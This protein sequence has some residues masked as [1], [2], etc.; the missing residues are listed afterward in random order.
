MMRSMRK[1][2][3]WRVSAAILLMSLLVRLMPL[4]LYVTPDE[5]IWVERSIRFVDAFLSGDWSRI[6]Q[7]GHPGLTTMVLGGIG[8]SLMRL[9]YPARSA[10]H[11]DWIARIAW[12]APENDEAFRHLAFFLPAGRCLTALTVSLGMVALYLLGR[13]RFG[14]RVARTAAV[15]LAL[16]PFYAGH[17]GL[18]HTDALQ[19]TFITLA[20]VA[21]YPPNCRILPGSQP[22]STSAINRWLRW[23]TVSLMLALAGLTK[24]LG[25]AAAP[26]LALA[27]M[28]WGPGSLWQRIRRVTLLALLTAALVVLLYPPSW[29]DPAAT[30]VSFSDAVFYHEGIGLRD[31]FFAGQMHVDPGP[32]FY[33][34]VLLFRLTPPVMVGMLLYIYRWLR[35][36]E[37]TAPCYFG[38]FALPAC[39]Y[40]VVITVATKKF[41]RYVLMTV[42]LL[43]I[44]AAYSWGRH[45]RAWRLTLLASL[46]LPWVW[47]AVAPLQYA[48]PLLG[49][50][51]SAQQIVPLG[52]GEASGFAARTLGRLLPAPERAAV[53]TRNVPGTAPYFEGEVQSW[54][55]AQLPCVDGV[56]GDTQDG[57]ILNKDAT[58]LTIH[59]GGRP[60]TTLWLAPA[61]PAFGDRL[62]APGSLPGVPT[63]AVAPV[64]SDVDLYRWLDARFG[65][66][67]PFIWVHAPRCYP[68]SDVQLA[69]VLRNAG[70]LACEPLAWDGSLEVERC[71]WTPTTSMPEPYLA[72]FEGALDLIAISPADPDQNHN[73]ITAPMDAQAPGPLTVLLRWQ[74]RPQR[75]TGNVN[76]YLALQPLAGDG[77]TW[78][79]GGNVLLD[80]RN[81]P[82][83]FWSPSEVVDTEGYVPIPPTLPP[84]SYRL[85]LRLADDQ[86]WLGFTQPD[87][88]FGGLDYEA[89]VVT[90][91][92]P[93]YPAASLDLPLPLD[94]T[95]AGLRFIGAEPPPEEVWAGE[96]VKFSLGVERLPNHATDNL[97]WRL[98]DEGDTVD[99]GALVWGAS[100]PP[101]WPVGHRYILR[102][103]P[104]LAPDLPEGIYTLEIYAGDSEKD[105]QTTIPLG[106]ITVRQRERR[107]TFPTPP[108][109]K[110]HIRAG[111]FADLVGA[112]TSIA[113]DG[114]HP[115]EPGAPI[116]V[117]LYWQALGS[118][119]EDYTV[120][121][122]A[123]GPDG[124][125]WGQSDAWPL[126][127]AAP[128]TSWIAGEVLLDPHTFTLSE[129]AP[130]G[131]YEL[132]AGVYNARQGTR[133]PL[134]DE[135]GR[136]PDDRASITTFRVAAP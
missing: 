75:I 69:G 86:G 38:W 132:F 63:S 81:W 136:R 12:L 2:P 130:P 19:A 80:S 109:R 103:A 53:M 49:G 4:N 88:S 90:V 133:Q 99:G 73:T 50:A 91:A 43:T 124:A 104:R 128:T 121:I 74:P 25:L 119:A 31:V 82:S 101:V 21:A 48:T 9:I 39:L 6:P 44:I 105:K 45:R 120:F 93:P 28:I 66:G 111:D 127:G 59:I 72:Q 68:L 98:V 94:D 131:T 135:E 11:L 24:L 10:A 29:I 32:A 18:L 106:D 112:D 85:V 78:I 3:V 7:P 126:A 70:S 51:R 96:R 76:V 27:L 64:G 108:A 54:T 123:V 95:A 41:D 56:I 46:L 23:G 110:L 114:S 83:A 52:W 134:Y 77:L 71:S 26:G 22:R 129:D 40:L 102:F 89:G 13:R 116:S 55:E 113:G 17:G 115:L 1:A 5:P 16:D 62:L 36:R 57:Q 117:T 65:E 125:T 37:E 34:A 61:L 35:E 79:E 84:G 87:G 20:V 67:A 100:K 14:E 33:P 60:L 15:F 58:P 92:P 122:H 97:A 8:V 107:F 42:P 30:L 118:A 47:V